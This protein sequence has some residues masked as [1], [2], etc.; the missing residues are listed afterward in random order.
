MSDTKVP[1]TTDKD[2]DAGQAEGVSGGGCTVQDY[3]TATEQLK[4]A[5]DNLVEFTSYVIERVDTSLK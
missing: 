5:Y 1:Q 2:L 3:I 4:A